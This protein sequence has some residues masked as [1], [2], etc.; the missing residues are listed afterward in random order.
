M[1]IH[2][3]MGEKGLDFSGTHVF[4]MPFVVEAES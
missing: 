3:Q 4:G 2:R 1:L